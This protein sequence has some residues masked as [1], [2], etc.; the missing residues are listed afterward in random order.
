MLLLAG[1]VAGIYR[2]IAGELLSSA[3]T[4]EKAQRPEDPYP[5]ISPARFAY[6]TSRAAILHHELDKVLHSRADVRA[7]RKR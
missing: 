5:A 4:L 7:K 6:A 3:H 1:E 2:G